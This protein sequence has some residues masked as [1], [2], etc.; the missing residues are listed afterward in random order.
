MT[1]PVL[2]LMHNPDVTVRMR[3]VMEKCTYCVQRLN[4]TRIEIKKLMAQASESPDVDAKAGADTLLGELQTACQQ[5]CP[6]QAIVFGDMNHKFADGRTNEVVRLKAQ[7]Q[8]YGVLDH[9]LNTK[10]RTSYLTRLTNPNPEMP[11][12]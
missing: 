3:G 5:A 2:Q 11:T 1:T 6:S 7:P 8:N 12:T 4:H 10:P 9:N